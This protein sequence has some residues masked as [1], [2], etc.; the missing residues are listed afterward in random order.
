MSL[1]PPPAARLVSSALHAYFNVTSVREKKAI[2]QPP[3]KPTRLIKIAAAAFS[4]SPLIDCILRDHTIEKFMLAASVFLGVA[5]SAD[6]DKV[7]E[8]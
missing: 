8:A 1:S 4:V 6:R 5:A 7:N 3:L 2:D